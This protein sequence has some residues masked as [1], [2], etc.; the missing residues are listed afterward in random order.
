MLLRTLAV[1]GKALERAHPERA[2]FL[3][4]AVRSHP[5]YK[6]GRLAFDMLELE[7]LMLDAPATALLNDAQVAELLNDLAANSRST[8]EAILGFASGAGNGPAPSTSAAENG[9]DRVSAAVSARTAGTGLLR[10][11]FGPSSDPMEPAGSSG[12]QNGP[13]SP[14]PEPQL[15]PSDYLYDYV[16]LGFLDKLGRQIA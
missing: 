3:L 1:R 8:I 4:A 16:V 14:E 13:S 10:V 5:L 7:D 15:L 9:G 2:E 6:G 12:S 11:S